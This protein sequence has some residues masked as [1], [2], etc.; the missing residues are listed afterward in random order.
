M[1]RVGIAPLPL[2]CRLA[3]FVLIL[4]PTLAWSPL[5]GGVSRVLGAAH[6]GALLGRRPHPRAVGHEVCCR[7]L[8][9]GADVAFCVMVQ[10]AHT[11]SPS[12]ARPPPPPPCLLQLPL[13]EAHVEQKGSGGL[14]PGAAGAGAGADP[15]A[16]GAVYSDSG[17]LG[18]LRSSLPACACCPAERCCASFV[19]PW[20]PACR[21]DTVH[22]IT[23]FLHT[24]HP[25]H[26]DDEGP[27]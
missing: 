25:A 3:K 9:S 17:Q 14:Q 24:H 20:A 18:P 6:R 26:T 10:V 16:A 5:Q 4:P 27:V 22:R 21:A 15:A 23:H 11:L 1:M 7:F 2:P 12:R 19:P 8:L 13:G